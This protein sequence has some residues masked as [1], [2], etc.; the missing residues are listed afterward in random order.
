MIKEETQKTIILFL[1]IVKVRLELERVGSP[2]AH[3]RHI[4][5]F[6]SQV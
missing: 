3:V 4:L 2:P 1:A 5:V 6:Q